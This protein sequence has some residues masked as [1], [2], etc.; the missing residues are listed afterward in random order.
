MRRTLLK[1]AVLAGALLAAPLAQA[2]Q[3]ITLHGASQFNDD[4]AFTKALV[5]F[6]EL[7]KQYYGKPIEFMSRGGVEVGPE[8][9]TLGPC[10]SCRAVPS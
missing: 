10:L 1:V 7:V 8:P 6:E 9:D 3:V 5:K 4:H 2:Q